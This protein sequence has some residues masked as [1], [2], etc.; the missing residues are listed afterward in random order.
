MNDK[1]EPRVSEFL[2]DINGKSC[3]R[4]QAAI[5]YQLL[6]LDNEGKGKGYTCGIC[7]NVIGYAFQQEFNG[8]P[9]KDSVTAYC[10]TCKIKTDPFVFDAYIPPVEL[11]MTAVK[12]AADELMR[13]TAR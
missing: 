12:A 2:I 10:K 6:V 11:A 7:G 4:N 5:F 3:N 13:R 1:Q 9:Y 8:E